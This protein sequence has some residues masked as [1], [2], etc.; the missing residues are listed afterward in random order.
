MKLLLLISLIA[1]TM[2]SHV[3]AE[4][5]SEARCAGVVGAA[6]LGDCLDKTLQEEDRHLNSVYALIMRMLDAGAVDPESAFFYDKKKD[7]VAAERAWF[8]YRD[9]QC[10]AE[11]TMIGRASA[12][13]KVTVISDCLS[14]MAKERVMYLNRVVSSLSFESRLCRA[15][16][17]ACRIAEVESPR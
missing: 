8:K 5:F 15:D 9:A 6:L 10:G 17:D 1:V 11:V 2:Q 14:K 13:G 3:Y 16:A 4:E 7:L 12:S